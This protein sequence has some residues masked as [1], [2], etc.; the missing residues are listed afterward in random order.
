MK[1][2]KITYLCKRAIYLVITCNTLN[3]NKMT[4]KS[5]TGILKQKLH[6]SEDKKNLTPLQAVP[7]PEEAAAIGLAL[8]LY[9]KEILDHENMTLTIKQ[10]SRIYSPWSSKI[11]G[12]MGWSRLR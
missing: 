2:S 3:F 12:V 4:N 11:Y 7:T 5:I 10:V 1:Y 8:D 9:V 6:L